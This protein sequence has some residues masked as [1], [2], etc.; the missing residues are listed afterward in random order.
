[1]RMS[2]WSSDV[3]S[4]DLHH[5]W[6]RPEGRYRVSEL[7]ADVAAG[8]DVRASVYVQCR[9]GY[10]TDGP[11]ELQPVGEVETIRA[12]ARERR[13]YPVGIIAFADL[14]LGSGA[15]QVLEALLEA[16]RKRVV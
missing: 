5:L 3:C 16:D 1:M 10:R 14:Q 15:S 8:H 9:T 13:L 4:S 12:W 7:M 2:D 11:V 6:D